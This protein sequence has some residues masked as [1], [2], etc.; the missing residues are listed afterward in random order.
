M[1]SGLNVSDVVNV[2]INLSPL[3]AAQRNFGALLIVGSS[4]IIDTNE[5]IRQYSDLDGIAEDFGTTAPEYLDADL[6]FSQTPQPSIVYVGRWAQTAS[7]GRLNGGVLSGAQQ[8]I[9]NFTGITNGSMKVDID[10][11]TKTLSALS[12][13]AVTNLNGVAAIIDTALA[14]ASCVWD[15]VSQRFVIQSDTT[16]TT[17]TVGYA[18]ATGSGTDISALLNLVTGV[19]SP[20]VAGI[21]AETLLAAVQAL[22]NMSND[23]YG[24]TVATATP[25]A[26]ADHLAVAAFIEGASASHIYGITITNPSV[27]DS[28]VTNDLAS[29]L[30]A[31]G[32][33]RTF[34][35]FSS[36]SPYA[37]A[38]M[39]GRAFTVNFEANNTT[40]TLK[41]KQEPGVSAETITES[42]AATLKSKNCNVFVNYNNDTAIIQEGV[43][44]NGYFFDEVHGTDWLQNAVQ[45]DVYNLLYQSATKIPQT[46]AG[47]HLI[48]TTIESTMARAVNNGLVAPGIWNAGGFGQLQQGQMLSSGYYVYAPLVASQSQA[49]RE[50]RKSVPIQVAAKLAG[51]VHSVNVLINVNR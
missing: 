20:P 34:T 10:G 46:D 38:S 24:L 25:P 1:A 3:A 33:K 41:F 9:S 2:S 7:S 49:D 27:L 45:T 39:Y 37:V 14:G 19:A 6:F 48:V 28:A 36:S 18:S 23:W 29:Q 4:D 8:Q 11:A 50:A 30:K 35:Q 31:L 44:A 43:M 51:A 15:S 47:T 42:Q 21:A 17:S 5:R 13:S 16:G 40:I 22:A 32:Y 26:S 12:F